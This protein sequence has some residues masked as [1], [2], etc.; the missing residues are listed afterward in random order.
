MLCRP[1]GLRLNVVASRVQRFPLSPIMK[2]LK[3]SRPT[4]ACHSDDATRQEIRMNRVVLIAGTV[5]H[6]LLRINN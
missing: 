1:I 2:F 3:N 5:L 6:L 4:G